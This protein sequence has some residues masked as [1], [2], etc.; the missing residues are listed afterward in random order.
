MKK[1]KKYFIFPILSLA[2]LLFLFGSFKQDSFQKMKTLTEI[3]RLVHEVY[4]EEPD[5]NNLMEGA[6]EIFFPVNFKSD[7]KS[8]K[9]NANLYKS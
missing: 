1:I 8:V 7:F 9:D 4:I 5:M 3:I 2:I 6:I